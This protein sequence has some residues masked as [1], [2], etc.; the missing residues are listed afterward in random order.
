VRVADLDDVEQRYDQ[1]D[2]WIEKCNH[3]NHI[4]YNLLYRAICS[5][6]PL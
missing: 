6:E 5:I 3:M 1:T 4:I 2:I